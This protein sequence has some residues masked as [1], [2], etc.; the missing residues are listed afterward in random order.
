[1]TA[2]DGPGEANLISGAK[3]A[4]HHSLGLVEIADFHS[5]QGR[6]RVLFLSSSDLGNI[7]TGAVSKLEA[8]HSL[9]ALH[10]MQAWN[11]NANGEADEAPASPEE[12]AP[13]RDAPFR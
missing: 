5:A 13:P 10:L 9:V 7:A 1:M 11:E 4:A 6:P 3:R 8:V 12:G 2:D